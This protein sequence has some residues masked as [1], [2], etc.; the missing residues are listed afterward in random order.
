MRAV[1]TYFL[2]ILLVINF[3]GWSQGS[4]KLIRQGNQ[5]YEDG[6]YRQ[7]EIDYLKSLE[8]KN[9]S[10]KG[11]YNL[12]DALYMQKNYAQA[13]AAFDS[14]HTFRMDDPTRSQAYYNLGNSLL[15]LAQ[16]SAQIASQALQSSINAYKQSLRIDPQDMDAKYNLAY[17]QRMLQ[18]QQQQDQKDDKQDQQDQKQDQ[19]QQDQQQQDQQQQQEQNQQAKEDQQQQQQQQA[20]PQKI[21]KENAE[22]MLEAMKNDEKKTLE[23]LK[24]AKIKMMRVARP[25]KDW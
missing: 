13:T 4:N 5:H 19:K 21:S 12:G 23:K 16:D 6:N 15:K 7:A 9:P 8:D 10:H 1:S 24:Q 14:L 17:A 25:E 11:M 18:Q 2:F 20:Q 22:R 3:T